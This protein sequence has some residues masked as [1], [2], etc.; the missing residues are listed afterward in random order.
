MNRAH[1]DKTLRE[2]HGA[3]DR[4]CSRMPGCSDNLP[5]RLNIWA[6]PIE[7]HGGLGYDLISPLYVTMRE[8]DDVDNEIIRLKVPLTMPPRSFG[9]DIGGTDPIEL[10]PQEYNQFVELQAGIGLEDDEGNRLPTLKQ[11]LRSLMRSDAYKSSSDPLKAL[12]IRDMIHNPAL[13]YRA[14]ARAVFLQ[15]NPEVARRLSKKK[16]RQ[17]IELLPPEERRQAEQQL[18]ESLGITP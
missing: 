10:T 8:P 3:M 2:T 14:I 6:E 18:L 13:G 1:F 17:D 11:S 16:I 7:L 15:K 12:L 5:P 9:S 4:I